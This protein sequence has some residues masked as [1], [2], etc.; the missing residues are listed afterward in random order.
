MSKRIL[1]M[2]LVCVMIFGMLPVVTL[3][4]EDE[5]VSGSAV[6]V[7]PIYADVVDEMTLE[8]FSQPMQQFYSAEQTDSKTTR[9][10]SPEEV[11]S[12]LREALESRTMMIQIPYVIPAESV[13]S[14]EAV[15]ALGKSMMDP[16]FAHTGVPTQGDYLQWQYLYWQIGISGSWNKDNTAVNGTV[17]FTVY[18]YTDADQ[19]AAVTSRVDS[20]LAEL[21]PSGTD[22]EKIKT[23]Y[24]WMCNHIE[25]DYDN[26]GNPNYYLQYTAYAALIN[27]TSVCQGYANLLYRLALELGIDCRIITGWSNSQN[28]AWN[29][30]KLG[31]SYYNL[32]A[33]WD[34]AYAQVGRDYEYFLRSDATFD[35]HVRMSDYTG[36]SFYAAYPMGANDYDPSQDV[37]EDAPTELETLIAELPEVSDPMGTEYYFYNQL[38]DI[39]KVLYWK[40]S[41]A[42]WENPEISIDGFEEYTHEERDYSAGRAMAALMA[43]DP[44]HH[45]YWLKEFMSG[46]TDSE[47]FIS[48]SRFPGVSEYHI[49]KA[50]ARAEE[51]VGIVGSEGDVYSRLRDLLEYMHETM[52]Y[53]HDV[54]VRPY[55]LQLGYDDSV[56]GCLLHNMAVCG[57]FSDTVKLLCD[58][59]RIPCIVVH[60]LNYEGAGA[61]AWNLV[62][63]ENGQWYSID[64]SADQDNRPLMGYNA[65]IIPC[66]ISYSAYDDFSFPVLDADAYEYNG[67]YISSYHTVSNKFVET[68]PRFL[69]QVN[70]DGE[71]CTI[72]GFEGLQVGDLIIPD[73]I[74]GYVVTAIGECAFLRCNGFSGDI[75]IPNTVMRI[76][77]GAF[78]Q[79]GGFSGK[80]VLPENLEMIGEY[81]FLGCKNLTGNL[82][83]PDN[84]E[85][86]E[87]GAFI[88][89]KGFSGD[90]VLPNGVKLGDN[91]FDY[92][93]GFN[94]TLH[95]PDD[96]EWTP[97]IVGDTNF[98]NVVVN[99]TNSRYATHDGILYTKDM[100]T[101]VWCP[102]GSVGDVVVPDGVEIIA[103]CSF[104][105]CSNGVGKII[106]PDGLKVIE[107]Y[108]FF[109]AGFS[110]ELN[111]PATVERIEQY[112]FCMTNFTGDLVIPDSVV[113]IGDG[114]FH[115]IP[116][117][118]ELH[119]PDSLK[120]IKSFTFAGSKFVG[121][122]VIPKSVT[123]IGDYAFLGCTFN[124]ELHL[125]ESLEYI[126][127]MAFADAGS[128]TMIFVNSIDLTNLNVEISE[129]AF[130]RAVFQGF[131]CNCGVEQEVFYYA[132]PTCFNSGLEY[133]GCPHCGG[134]VKMI[135][136]KKEHTLVID[137]AIEATC[138]DYGLTEGSHC[139]DCGIS[140][141]QQELVQPKGHN[142]GDW[143]ITDATCTE[144]GSKTRICS[145]CDFTETEVIPSPGHKHETVVTAP[146]CT[147]VGYTTHTCPCGDTYVDGE[148]A[149]LGHEYACAMDKVPTTDVEGALRVRCRN[150]DLKNTV[151]LPKL[152]KTDYAYEV[153]KESTTEETGTARYT[154]NVTEYG[155]HSFEVELDKLPTFTL[156]DVNGDD[157]ITV[158]DLMRLA[159]FFAGKDVEIS[160]EA[161][162]VNGDGKV[163]VLD[164]M[165]LAN[166]F[167]GKAQLG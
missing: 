161:A 152:N 154:W 160:E 142:M 165:R 10:T 7:N 42:T 65:S 9:Y 166:Y 40:I 114:A 158:L 113:E 30:V 103:K 8:L 137:E 157:K 21:H 59:L 135:L 52:D 85:L 147:E 68:Q 110:G 164:L 41:E 13:E 138:E 109:Q 64:T 18:Y 148:R 80:L 29:I 43:D 100:K 96:M 141:K 25:Y 159:N 153:I 14:D 20:L 112:A 88:N 167:A 117:G 132:E 87:F 92:C 86:V 79:C 125:H 90:L 119:I 57:G 156:G 134:G 105:T 126:G 71:T 62:Q 16:A 93:E 69:Y 46:S 102:T 66:L 89:C 155:E 61:H 82:V 94:G 104:D 108:A 39:E 97:S 60:T 33:T 106:L 44:E 53:N 115:A 3:A 12:I 50:Y 70:S 58:K 116:F 11:T 130:D 95:L 67:G 51:I 4:A 151:V 54:L 83:L 84:L 35:D 49:Q 38:T 146:T 162:D 23:V 72:I 136:E 163:T 133:I 36:S 37:E 73:T 77:G 122:L 34:T 17:T 128:D 123:H 2:L 143:V 6:Y 91:V 78:Y 63:M 145:R 144:D 120:E 127:T 139:A 19:E 107:E 118:G 27:G 149:A 15:L 81:A 99:Q 76:E 26:L 45:M 101:L 28:H 111:I 47:Y 32:D 150:C 75:I 55:A 1:S 98:R 74:N 24:D 31:D 129:D 140:F 48:L 131:K 5:L 121:D 22:Y 56:Y 124:G